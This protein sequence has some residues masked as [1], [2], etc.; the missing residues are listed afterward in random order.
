M[1]DLYWKYRPLLDLIGFAEGTDRGRKY[2]ET[3]AYGAYTGG[4]VELVKMSLREI[5]QLQTRMLA[6]PANKWNSSAVGRYQI[7]RTTLRNIKKTLKLSDTEKYDEIMQDRM[8]CFLLGSRGIDRWLAGSMSTS[9]M[10]TELAKEWASFPVWSSNPNSTK[11]YYKGQGNKLKVGTVVQAMEEVKK[12][13]QRQP[14]SAPVDAPPITQTPKAKGGWLPWLLAA[15]GVGI[16]GAA[17]Y[18]NLF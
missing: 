11:S 1:S 17:S 18:F 16:A 4:N 15:A 3:L 5:D 7:V 9:A 6:H 12:R 14:V 10:V 13:H 2:N 8:G